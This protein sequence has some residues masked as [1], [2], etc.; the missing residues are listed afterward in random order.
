[1]PVGLRDEANGAPVTA[2]ARC[3]TQA[4]ACWK[5]H[6]EERCCGNR[7]ATLAWNHPSYSNR[8]NSV[9]L[10]LTSVGGDPQHENM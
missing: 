2:Q 5:K 10:H 3:N 7:Q 8:Y 6:E 4:I 1:M 9:H